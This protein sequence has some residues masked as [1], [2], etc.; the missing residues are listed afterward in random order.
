MGFSSELNIVV[1]G[2]AGFIGSH[3]CDRLIQQG[4]RVFCIDNLFTGAF[5]N[6]R[7]LINHRNFEFIEHDVRDPLEIAGKADRIYNLACPASPRP[8]QRDPIGTLRTCVVGAHNVVELARQKGARALQ[9]STS[10]IYGD[11]EIHPQPEQYQGNVNPIG[12]RACYDEGKRA[13]ETL[14]FDYHRVHGVEIKVARI[15]NTYGPRMLENDGRVVSN[16][17]VQALRGAPITIYG[18]GHQTR[19][20][21]YVDDLIRGLE[22]L[23]ESDKSVTGPCNLGNPEEITIEEIA[24]QILSQSR[25]TSE[26]QHKPLP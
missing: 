18:S 7:P 17:I 12:P 24:Q 4:H 15:F 23:M 22:L 25:S 20:F 21:C 13:A 19:S 26:L 9:A 2:G 6:I 8:Y 14:F 16:F 1:T 11:P 10:E 3:L 5:A